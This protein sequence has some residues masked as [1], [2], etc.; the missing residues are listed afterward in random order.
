MRD[1]FQ[2]L[3][4]REQLFFP[5]FERHAITITAAASALR[6]ML[7][8]GEQIREHCQSVMRLEE[9]ADAITRDVLVGVRSTFITPFDRGDIKDL[10]TAMD[11]A[12]DQMQKTAKAIV[13]F[14]ITTFE[15][16]M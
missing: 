10:I 7:E 13:L 15:P 11:D 6:R 4:P 14:E 1:W 5:L 9:Q 3:M 16:E 8:G 12:I 2:R